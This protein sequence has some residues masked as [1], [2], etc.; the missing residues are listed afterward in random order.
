MPGEP[1]QSRRGGVPEDVDGV[2][3]ITLPIAGGD[4]DRPVTLGRFQLGAHLG[5]GG[6]GS[7]FEARDTSLGRTVA[8]KLLR[9]GASGEKGRA[10]LLREAQALA[11]LKH[12][13]I[14]TV[15][16]VGVAGEE[17]FVAME[18]VAGG[19]LREWMVSPHGWREVTDLFLALGR[20]LATA[21]ALGLVHR[22]VKPSNI[23]LDL[24]G[25]PKLG[26]FGLVSPVGASE[27]VDSGEHRPVPQ[28]DLT[29]SG[30]VMGT[31]AYMSPEQLQGQPADARADQFAYCAAFHEA[32]TGS[33]PGSGGDRVQAPQRL[34]RILDRGLD[35]V[36][37]ARYP[38]MD[39]LLDDLARVRRGRTRL[40]LGLA[41]AAAVV[42]AA[43][44]SWTAARARDLCPP[45]TTRLDAA[46]GTTRRAALRDHLL[47]V[48][49]VQGGSRFAAV[50]GRFDPFAAGLRDQ[51]V[52]ACRATRVRGT[53]SDALLDLRMRCLDRRLTEFEETSSVLAK[54]QGPEALDRAVSG[55]AQLPPLAD[56]ADVNALQHSTQLPSRPEAR[57]KAEALSRKIDQVSA[58]ER[59]GALQDLPASARALVEEARALDHPPTL[60]NALAALARVQMTVGDSDA[61]AATLREVAQVAARAHDDRT[62]AF[63]WN[64]LIKITGWD[65]SKPEEAK[66]LFPVAAAAVARA[67]EPI[68]LR[69]DML[70]ARAATLKRAAPRDALQLYQDLGK[71]LETAGAGARASSLYERLAD[72]FLNT[73][74]LNSMLGDIAAAE[75]GYQRVIGMYRDLY[76]EDSTAEAYVWMNRGENQRVD[77]KPADALESYRHAMRIREQRLGDSTKL[78]AAITAVSTALSELKRWDEALAAADRALQMERAHVD[79]R[80]PVLL[81]LM[82]AHARA[83]I[84]AGRAEDGAREYDEAIAFME[85]AHLT[86]MNLPITVYNRAELF[87]KARQY[88]PALNGYEK[89]VKLFEEMR[90][91]ENWI[92][93]YPLVDE[94][95]CLVFAGRP[96]A[97]IPL[98]QRALALKS[99]GRAASVVAQGRFYLAR[100][101][102]ESGSNRAKGLA[103]AAAARA[104]AAKGSDQEVL[105][106][107]DLWLA[108]HR[109]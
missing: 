68:D 93:V 70:F 69:A 11:R 13:N 77:G 101:Q 79:A 4:P 37:A 34:R 47:S 67:G 9:P 72:D 36:A 100:A 48:D 55:A 18:L 61:A 73:A 97:A 44:A 29:A 30:Q 83:L 65:L 89:A 86:N 57:A 20:G 92:L 56:C 39:A 33:L 105:D 76:G 10:R 66:P 107:M 5:S 25:T 52:E 81:S 85:G 60:S 51:S 45:P 71:L 74:D 59:A 46:W 38:S 31:P 8:I 40:W 6:M 21:H 53:Q 84:D 64:S 99:P 1:S 12:P 102:V 63:A 2:D 87:L 22:D 14:V 109:R 24:D 16:E 104:T 106:E 3:R 75:A 91:K 58:R 103:D 62:A 23:F 88:Q 28:G 80:S 54:V 108:S 50:S 19:T 32:L 82:V 41:G 7:V 96:K 17:V 43:S 90:G 49:P 15:F 35:P 26:D 27:A 42:T 98:L 78:A 95:R 94:G